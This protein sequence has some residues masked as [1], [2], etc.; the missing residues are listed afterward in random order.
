MFR[1]TTI[2]A[3]A[4]ATCAAPVLAG[5]ITPVEPEPAPMVPVAPV[6]PSSPDW[7][8]FYAGGQ[9]G[10]ANVDTN[11]AGVD[12]DD[13]IGGLLLG[14]DYDMGNWV[15][16]GGIDYDFADISLSP[17]TSLEEVW[18]VKL[19][20]GYK[21]GNGLLY[22]TG[23][24]AGA[25]TSDLGSED[26]Y[27]VGGGYEHMLSQNFSLGGEVLYHE[28]EGFGPA[29]AVDAEATTVQIRASYRF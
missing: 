4:L 12:G 26:G 24:Y 9:L 19:R 23:G 7:T 25:D 3:A 18:R 29:N 17:T 20:G 1:K 28:F 13:I 27:F 2:L 10:Y 21:L 5:N 14:Y 15:V 16:G 6:A 8:G 11:V 22:A